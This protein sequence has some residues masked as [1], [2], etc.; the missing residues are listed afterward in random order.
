MRSWPPPPEPEGR[1]ANPLFSAQP[2]RIKVIEVIE[3]MEGLAFFS[4]R[5]RLLP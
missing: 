5:G 1:S 3:V 4:A 2:L